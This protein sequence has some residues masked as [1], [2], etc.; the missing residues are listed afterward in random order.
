MLS[1]LHNNR[2]ILLIAI[3]SVA[4]L[5][6]GATQQLSL[7]IHPRYNLFS[8]V[9]SLIGI[10]FI[11]FSINSS[12]NVPK[13]LKIIISS[14]LIILSL[15]SLLIIK[16]TTLSSNIASQRG[17]NTASSIES[18]DKLSN[19]DIVSPFDN[20]N[21]QLNVKEWAGL[22]SQ[23]NDASFFIDKKISVDG[24]ITKDEKNSENTFYVSRFIVSCCAVD[25][26]PVGVAVNSPNWSSEFSENQ[27]V[28]VEGKL[29]SK[30]G[31]ILIEPE[32]ITKIE[33]PKDPY[34][35]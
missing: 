9:F 28:K 10:V 27:W 22:I 17:M 18:L 19:S 11:I 13:K 6:L 8:I 32:E 21:L 30:D 4:T 14:S 23:T 15:I 3:A 7:Y 35:Y 24:F 33:Q 31:L 26:R 1:K 34:V 5:W 16:P 2:G 12:G 20:Q 25:A 29:A